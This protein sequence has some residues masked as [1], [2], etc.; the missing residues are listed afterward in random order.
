M[1]TSVHNH[2]VPMMVDVQRCVRAVDELASADSLQTAV[3]TLIALAP[4]DP[5]ML[6]VSLLVHESETGRAEPAVPVP[7][8][9]PV[10]AA[11]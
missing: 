6:A 2:L 4:P 11:H 7:V 3:R 5:A 10:A 8:P 1:T 9:V